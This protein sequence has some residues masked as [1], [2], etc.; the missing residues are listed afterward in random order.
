MGEMVRSSLQWL[1]SLQWCSGCNRAIAVLAQLLQRLRSL[2]W[3]DHC[4]RVMAAMV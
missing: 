2:Q 3:C 4:D 1:Q